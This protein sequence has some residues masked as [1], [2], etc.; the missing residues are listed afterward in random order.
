ML[1]SIAF[2]PRK[3]KEHML[4]S[5]AFSPRKKKQRIQLIIVILLTL[6]PLND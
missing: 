6:N 4:K 1:N 2:S 3:K 5:I